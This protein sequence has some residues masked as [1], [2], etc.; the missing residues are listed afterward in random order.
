MGKSWKGATGFHFGM[1][2]Q[3]STL[4]KALCG[5]ALVTHGARSS[6]FGRDAAIVTALMSGKRNSSTVENIFQVFLG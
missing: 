6:F 4:T 5:G 1:W 3:I 2:F